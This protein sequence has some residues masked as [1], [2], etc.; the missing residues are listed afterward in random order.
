MRSPR[1]VLALALALSSLA[2]CAADP[3]APDDALGDNVVGVKLPEDCAY[4]ASNLTE[5]QRGGIVELEATNDPDGNHRARLWLADGRHI[6]DARLLYGN[7]GAKRRADFFLPIPGEG[8]L[9]RISYTFERRGAGVALTPLG[10]G[11]VWR[12]DPTGLGELETAL[13]T[14]IGRGAQLLSG[15][16]GFR[17]AADVAGALNELV[18]TGAPEASTYFDSGGALRVDLAFT[19]RARIGAIARDVR[20][21]VSRT[22]TADGP[23]QPILRLRDDGAITLEA[24]I[25]ITA[26][27][28]TVE[29]DAYRAETDAVTL[30]VGAAVLAGRRQLLTD[31]HT[32]PRRCHAAADDDDA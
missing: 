13:T 17:A 31:K 10:G 25:A 12:L 32:L 5:G 9:P 30:K 2:A 23:G 27:E 8:T 15:A 21:E 1:L 20:C 28:T 14:A 26:F 16:D 11:A 4:M 19:C 22:S 18:P 3:D 6:E 7:E 24:P 29:N